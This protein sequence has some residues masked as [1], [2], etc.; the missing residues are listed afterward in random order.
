MSFN[1]YNYDY[2]CVHEIFRIFS[3]YY[4]KILNISVIPFSRDSRSLKKNFPSNLID[5]LNLENFESWILVKIRITSEKIG[6][7]KSHDWNSALSKEPFSN[8]Q[9]KKIVSVISLSTNLQSINEQFLKTHH[10]FKQ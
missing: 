2:Y 3:Y 1:C 10:L 5:L 9:F 8:L 4:D 6:L 7:I